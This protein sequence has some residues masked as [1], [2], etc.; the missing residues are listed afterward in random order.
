MTILIAT[1]IFLQSNISSFPDIEKIGIDVSVFYHFGIFFMLTF[2][3]TL[4]L[5]DKKIENKTIV[6]ILLVSL[7]YALSDEFHQL[8]VVGRVCSLEDLAIDF[9]GSICSVIVVK[10]LE[11]LKKL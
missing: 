1:V 9:T 5:I 6:I 8:F 4:S 3:L 7:A 2:F 11:K 10:A